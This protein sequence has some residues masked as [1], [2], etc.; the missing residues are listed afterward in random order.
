MIETESLL[1]I[2][3]TIT[4]IAVSVYIIT[5]HR[6]FTES[7]IPV[8]WLKIGFAI[9][10]IAA[11]ALWWIY[12]Q[13]YTNRNEADTF[14][15]FDDSK[16]LFDALK[17]SPIDYLKMLTGIKADDPHLSTYYNEMNYWYDVYTPVNDNR[18]I[19]RLQAFIRLFS[20]GSYH[21]HMVIV[22]FLSLIGAVALAKGIGR[23][24][25]DAEKTIYALYII[26]PSTC[27]WGSGLMKDSLAVFALGITIFQIALFSKHDLLNWKK[28]TWLAISLLLLMFIRFQFF[29]LIT[30]L[31]LGWTKML[32][33]A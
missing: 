17:E 27:F 32:C 18:A 13:H 12:S 3:L 30:P 11:I 7:N 16:V 22:C 29:L 4:F 1:Q 33:V 20:F 15:Y 9:K 23:F 8:S 21:V 6:F 14:R 5:K 28:L 25:A 26:I 10:L 2:A 19:I 31:L 24:H